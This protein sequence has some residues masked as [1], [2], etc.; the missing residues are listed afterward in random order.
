M[1][2]KNINSKFNFSFIE[3]RLF[4]NKTK[5]KKKINFEIYLNFDKKCPKSIFILV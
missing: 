3:Y 5:R 1:I 4:S 2:I